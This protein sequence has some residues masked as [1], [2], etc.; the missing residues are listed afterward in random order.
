L[1]V[2]TTMLARAPDARACGGCFHGPPP[3]G[4]TVD[5]VITDHRMVFSISTAQ[6]VLWDQIRYSGSPSA[7]AWVLPVKPGTTIALSY[8]AWIASL[9]AATQTVIQGPTPSC[10]GPAPVQDYSDEGS[11]GGGGCGSSAAAGGFAGSADS[12][13]SFSVDASEPEDAGNPVQV[14]TQQVVGPYDSVTVHSSQGEALAAWLTANGYVVP[15]ALQPL[16]DAFT[17][18]GFD[19]IALKLAPGEGVQAMQPVRVVTPGAD[20]SLPLRMVAAGVGAN[21][22]LELWVL[23]E[24]IWQTQN[25]PQSTIDFTQLAWDPYNVVSNYT[26]LEAQALAQ[27]GGRGWVTESAGP[28]GGY[29]LSGNPPLDMTY[30]TT[31]V[32]QMIVPS[33][34]GAE[35]GAPAAIDAGE[36]GAGGDAGDAADGGDAGSPL[37]AGAA[38]DSGGGTVDAGSCAPVVI[39]CDDLD[40]AMT[41]IDPGSFTVT[42]LH[43]VL[44]STALAADLVLE[45]A[46]SQATVSNFH[47]TQQYTDPSYNPCPPQSNAAPAT[48]PQPSSQPAD[49]STTPKAG[50]RYAD[51]LMMLLA[52]VGVAFGARRRRRA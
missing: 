50:T 22:G 7:F 21:V 30:Q 37:E 36:G 24:G 51:V 48:Q 42:R 13:A 2:A 29:V 4:Q 6:T 35:A 40:V 28:V 27:N 9:D 26:T 17:T 16:I 32:P 20:P 11:G 45:A 23:G 31:C 12:G 43:A 44:P 19:F 41:G 25:F 49:C 33:A 3:P 1:I 10:G 5:S 52:A 8:D 34:C 18:E 46:A 47:V 14:V 38:A 15:A 39:P